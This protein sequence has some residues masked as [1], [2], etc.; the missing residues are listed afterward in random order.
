MLQES[1][2]SKRLD[3]FLAVVFLQTIIYISIIFDIA[4]ARQIT[5]FLY[6]TFIP[7][8]LIIKLL[9]FRFGTLE[10]ATFSV[11]FSVAF[12]MLAGLFL[13]ELGFILGILEPLSV[14][15][16]LVTLNLLILVIAV[17]AY[18]RSESSVMIDKVCLSSV[19]WVTLIMLPLIL[20]VVGAMLVNLYADNRVLLV[21]ILTISSIMAVLTLKAG[22]P[23]KIYVVTVFVI[24]ISLLY[25]SSLISRYLCSFGS[26]IP[27]EYCTFKY[28]QM[29]GHWSSIHPTYWSLGLGRLNNMLSITI[30]PTV[31]CSLLNLDSTWIFKLIFPLIFAFVPLGLYCLWRESLGDKYAFISVFFFMATLAFYTE[32]LGLNRQM[33]GEL[34]FV[35]MLYVLLNKNIR[36]FQ[37][38]FSFT[39][40]GFSLIVSHYALAEIFLFFIIFAW[41]CLFV[42]KR[43]RNS[44]LTVGMVVMFFAMMFSWYIYTSNASVFKSFLD[45]ADHVYRQF[46]DFFNLES[47]GETV[48]RGLGLEPSPTIWNTIS[49]FFAYLTEILIV[50]GFVG[51][52]FK[53]REVNW[54]WG[55]FILTS[56]AMG[57]LITIIVVP[58]LASVMNMTR[59]YHILLFL[60]APLFVLGG[61]LLVK[62][63]FKKERDYMVSILL[64]AV[65]LPYFLFQTGFVYEVVKAESWS[66]PLSAYRMS[67][68][69]LY[70]SIGYTDD[71]SVFSARWLSKNVHVQ[72]A[73]VLADQTSLESLYIYGLVYGGY[74]YPLS[75]V[76]ILTNYEIVYLNSLNTFQ[77][78]VFAGTYLFNSSELSFLNGMNQV[79]S[80]GGS[81]I[82]KNVHL[83]R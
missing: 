36:S 14:Y 82:Y 69:K 17:L 33:I 31:Y 81:E 30:L 21:M 16:L 13:N 15:P 46:G 40:F 11:G 54:D 19:K 8:Y 76:T 52:L 22:F 24:G 62:S 18:F 43:H 28:T 68:Y 72:Q 29:Q 83:S 48:L 4:V 78:T 39:I 56:E 71:W 61:E 65:L 45:F 55:R 25:H 27:N 41:I 73:H 53:K 63:L 67:G 20:S 60:L 37:R 44:N 35:L 47:R 7:G 77:E 51:L 50:V 79:Y 75:N 5:G 23:S 6:F 58:G 42:L 1:G 74:I 3:F 49:R 10:M 38:M 26:D 70:Y 2:K 9:K 57:F 66:V 80:N 64:L 12:L 34:F 32:L 59:F